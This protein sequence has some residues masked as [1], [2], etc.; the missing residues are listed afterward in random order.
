MLAGPRPA[1]DDVLLRLHEVLDRYHEAVGALCTGAAAVAGSHDESAQAAGRVR[2]TAELDA[3]AA[4]GAV[5]LR[6]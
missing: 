3:T 5:G 4:V 2:A 6:T 1:G